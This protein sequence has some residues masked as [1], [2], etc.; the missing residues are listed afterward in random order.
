VNGWKQ[1]GSAFTYNCKTKKKIERGRRN[2]TSLS[3]RKFPVTDAVTV[4][5]KKPAED[6][7][8]SNGADP[9]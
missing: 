5:V 9:S 2:N 1:F 7:K 6:L 4:N 8:G 3:I